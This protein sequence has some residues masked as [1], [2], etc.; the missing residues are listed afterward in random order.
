[1]SSEPYLILELDAHQADAGTQTRLE[2]F[3]E[4][5]NNYKASKTKIE[6]KPFQISQV[7]RREGKTVV[8]TSDGKKLDIKDP[9]V[10][11][12]FI[13]FSKY[14]SDI[15]LKTFDIFGFNVGPS[16]DIKLE[17]PV[18][19]LRYTSGKECVPLPIVIGHILTLVEN[20]KPGEIIGFFMIRG[21]APCAVYSYFDYINQFLE[22]NKIE[23]VFLYRFDFLTKFLG[24]NLLSVLRYAPKVIITAD[25]VLET[26]SALR[27]VGEEGSL[28]LLHTYWSEFLTN[29][30]TKRQLNKNINKLIDKIAKIPRKGS[31]VDFPRVIIS[32]DFFVRFSPFFL[33]ELK[34]IY[35]KHNIIVK[36]TDMFELNLYS[37]FYEGGYL[38]IKQWKKDPNKTSSIIRAIATLWNEPSRILILSK[39]AVLYMQRLEKKQRKRFEKTGLLFAGPNNL[40]EIF[41]KAK[42]WISPLIFGEA[43]PTIG[44]GLET[45]EQENFD[46]LILTGPINCLPYKISQAIL[47]P[48]YLEHGVPFLVF[49]VDIIAI[50][51]NMRRLINANIEQIKR[52]RM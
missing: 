52:R 39:I 7:K 45:L 24:M 35:S 10:K 25:L 30:K 43:I 12:N 28:N 51:P 17:Y 26:E 14:H 46:S 20:R 15:V 48:I 34:E 40:K 11:L 18:K 6:K 33:R 27:V 1:M 47:K 9:R 32:G 36:S 8:I 23:N 13:S 2:A 3:L 19:G 42:K 29:S 5:I 37:I 49:D 38:V 16:E 44:K 50:S 21:G 41:K 31:P 22:A 4:I